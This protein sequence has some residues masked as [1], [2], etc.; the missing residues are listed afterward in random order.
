MEVKPRRAARRGN[1]RTM[2]FVCHGRTKRPAH[3]FALITILFAATAA[4]AGSQDT[5]AAPKLRFAVILTRHGIRSPTWALPDLNAYSSQPWPDWGVAPGNLTPRG[6]NLMTLFGS[7]YRLYFAA[8]GLLRPE[9]CA[10]AGYVYIRA[11]SESRTLETGRALATGMMPGCSADVHA[12]NGGKDP[13]FSPLSAGLAKPDRALA[14]ASISGRIG[15]NPN[16]LTGTYRQAFDTL[17][18]VLFGCAPDT[19]CPEEEKPGKKSVLK[20]ASSVEAGEG[21]HAADLRGPLRIGSTLSEDFLLEYANGM[22]GKDLGWGRLNAGRLREVLTLHA[23]Y[24]DL[25]RQTPYVARLQG[26]NLLS[27]V[28]R[29][30]EQAVKESLVPGSLGE[31]RDRVLI[32]IGHDTNISNIAGLLGIS[33]LLEGYPRDDTPPGGALVFELWQQ[34]Q[35]EMAVNTYYVAQSLEQMRKSTPLTLDSPP[36]KSPIFVPGCST[37]DQKMTCPWKA[38]QHTIESA[39][40]PAFVK[41]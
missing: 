38:F 16:A 17:R 9:G 18:E 10:D 3:L 22:E 41:P 20:Q 34:P 6:S 40:D 5:A 8:A 2:R 24:A 28:L 19:S 31:V 12:A 30:M 27:H 29:S 1:G 13:L 7:Y 15:A 25:A 26:S 23:A 4:T 32:I 37:A 33:W 21:D 11:D 14:A 35:G 39:I 36:L